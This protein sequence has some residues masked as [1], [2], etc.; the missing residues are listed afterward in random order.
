MWYWFFKYTI[1]SAIVRLGW[2]AKISGAKNV[3]D[4][5]GAI[6]APNHIA[7]IDSLV[8]PALLKRRLTYPAK[9]ELFSGKGFKG[10]IVA[11]FL[12]AIG[13]VPMDRSGGRASAASLGEIGQVLADGNLVG[14]Y[15]EG[16]RSPDGRLYKG[17]T[18]AA[19]MALQAQVP[20]IPVGVMHTQT[21]KKVLGIGWPSKP[22]VV[23]G[24]PM[25]FE[26]YYDHKSNAKVLRYVTD[27]VM[28]AIQELTGQ[29]YADVYGFR[30]KHGDL[31]ATGSDAFLKA[32]PGEGA[33]KPVLPT[34]Q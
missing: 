20:I 24:E 2:R 27:Q 33:S 4:S 32:H 9:A 19:R 22:R 15:P 10:K 3:P 18:G 14:I 26:E 31:K 16:T 11:W 23:V 17:K 13:Q 1:F 7:N 12:R 34:T 28:A 30:V 5:G 25:W 8:I 29:E 21:V 6:I